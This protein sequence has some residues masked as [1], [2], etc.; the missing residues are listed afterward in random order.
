MYNH[1][2][3]Y[4]CTLF[5]T[6]SSAIPQI[7]TVP[8][9]AGNKASTPFSHWLSTRLHLTHKY[10]NFEWDV[11]MQRRWD[12][13]SRLLLPIWSLTQAWCSS[14]AF[15]YTDLAVLNKLHDYLQRVLKIC[16]GPGFLARSMIWLLHPRLPL[17]L[18]SS[19][20]DTQEDWEREIS[21]WRE[22][23]GGDGGGA[24]S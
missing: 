2:Y 11:A 21:C 3:L 10:P 17:P 4:L 8:E 20:G 16:R 18:V 9:C 23:G 1:S 15:L 12:V 6:A 13:V 5:S 14:S 19:I 24:K 22:R 7:Y